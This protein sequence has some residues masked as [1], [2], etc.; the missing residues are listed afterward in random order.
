MTIAS[1]L[2]RK[3]TERVAT[4]ASGLVEFTNQRGVELAPNRK[5]VVPFGEYLVSH[6]LISR[7]QL[8]RAIQ[9]QDRH[10]DVRIG[11]CVVALGYLQLT[12]VED[13]YVRY[14]ERSSAR[15]A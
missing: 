4:K 2:H 15:A 1:L 12:Q 3:V 7:Y 6:E 5:P 10:A 9:L 8:F 13:A 11:E 14:A